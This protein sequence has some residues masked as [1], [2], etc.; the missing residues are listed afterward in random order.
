MIRLSQLK[1][2]RVLARDGTQIVGSVRRLLLDRA[3]NSI[4]ALQLDGTSDSD[5]LVEWSDLAAIAPDA[6]IV[7]SEEVL[8]GPQTAAEHDLL[9]G[10]LE[11][12]GKLVLTETG[13]EIGPLNDLAFD[14]RS[15][16]LVELEV[17]GHVVPASDVVALGPY[18][19]IVPAQG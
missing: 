19:L 7:D 6:L 8:R 1:G 15:G 10:R 5:N 18:A 13:D 17:P 4:V 3:T 11:L 12:Q 2:Q 16:Q 9:A 14:E